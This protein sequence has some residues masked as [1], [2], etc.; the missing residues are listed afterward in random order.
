M[1]DILIA[2]VFIAMVTYPAVVA[3]MSNIDLD[4]ETGP[5]LANDTLRSASGSARFSGL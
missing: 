3:S 1:H 4:E 5:A 2:L